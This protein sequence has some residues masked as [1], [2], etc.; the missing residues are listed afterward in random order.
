M[1]LTCPN[2]N[3]SV[4]Q[5]EY[6]GSKIAVHDFLH[7]NCHGRY[8]QFWNKTPRSLLHCFHPHFRWTIWTVC[9]MYIY[10]YIPLYAIIFQYFPRLSKLYSPYCPS[11]SNIISIFQYLCWDMLGDSTIVL[12]L[13]L[14]YSNILGLLKLL[15]GGAPEQLGAKLQHGTGQKLGFEAVGGQGNLGLLGSLQGWGS[16]MFCLLDCKPMNIYGL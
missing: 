7:S 3:C 14:W 5:L 4:S 8:S 10:I 6:A 1:I 9:F 2:N 16:H 13:I 12:K 11:Y 15:Q